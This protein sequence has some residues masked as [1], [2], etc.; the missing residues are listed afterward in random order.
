MPV[1]KSLT[2]ESF[3]NIHWWSVTESEEA[4]THGIQ[5]SKNSLNR[6]AAMKSEIHRRGFLSIRHLLLLEGYQDADLTY[7]ESGKPMLADGSFITISHSFNLT[8]IAISKSY[9]IG[10]DLEMK[11][12]K[13][14]LIAKKFTTFHSLKMPTLAR[15]ERLTKIWCAKEAVY[16]VANQPGLSFLNHMNVEFQNQQMGKVMV[17][18]PWLITTY[19][20]RFIDLDSHQFA[21]ALP[22]FS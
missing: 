12:P 9:D 19:I 11:R 1:L 3:V 6:L 20:I 13:I 22:D 15:I 16:K 5:L 21:I 8:C 4:L 10:I 18:S 14:Q 2:L 7:H 17:S